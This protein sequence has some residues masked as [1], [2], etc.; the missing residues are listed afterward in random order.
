VRSRIPKNGGVGEK[1]TKRKPIRDDTEPLFE[2]GEKSRRG[3]AI[4]I[5]EKKRPSEERRKKKPPAWKKTF[6]SKNRVGGG[7][8]QQ[9]EIFGLSERKKSCDW[10]S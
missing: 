6:R 2:E 5:E 10:E 3:N 8:F 7:G 4:K 1:I 9:T